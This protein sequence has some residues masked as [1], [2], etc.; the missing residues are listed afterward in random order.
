[1]QQAAVTHLGHELAALKARSQIADYVSA[2]Y[3]NR[4]S[5]GEFQVSPKGL[6]ALVPFVQSQGTNTDLLTDSDQ[7]ETGAESGGAKER[8]GKEAPG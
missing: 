2:G 3:L 5:P 8:A 4:L 1:M 6:D 7:A